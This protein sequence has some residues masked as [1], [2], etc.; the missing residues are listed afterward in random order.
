M[1]EIKPQNVILKTLFSALVIGA[2]LLFRKPKSIIITVAIF[3]FSFSNNGLTKPGEVILQ[4]SSPGPCPQGLA[5]D[6]EYLWVADDSTDTI[7][8]LNPLDG[9]VIHSFASPGSKPRG[10]A[11]G[12]S[13]LWSLDDSDKKIFE[14]DPTTGHQMSSLEAPIIVLKKGASPLGGLAWGGQNLWSGVIAGWSSKMNRLDM[15]DGSVKT[16]HYTKGVPRA[17]AS[18]GRF[19]WSATDNRGHNFG[20][21]YKYNLSNGI[22]V[23]HIKTPGYYPTG[24]AFDGQHI[25]CGD[26]E[27][28]TIYK[29]ELK[30]ER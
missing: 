14:L 16:F 21:I 22:Y 6:G 2:K 4:F 18:D 17:L 15:S 8:K 5:W 28:K 13:H 12:N 27:T 23:S 7:Y 30:E 3:L 29:F 11:W 24:L 19:L 26:K 20:T 1:K 25:W 9:T 10:L